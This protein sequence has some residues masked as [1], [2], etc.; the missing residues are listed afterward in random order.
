MI[1][2]CA[3]LAVFMVL[4]TTAFASFAPTTSPIPKLRGSPVIL[5]NVA[6]KRSPIP[7]MRD[8]KSMAET[9]E[10]NQE[11]TTLLQIAELQRQEESFLQ[12]PK[13]VAQTE[14][15]SIGIKA[16]KVSAIPRLR[17]KSLGRIRD[18]QQVVASTSTPTKPERPK[19]AKRQRKKGSVC[20]V[21]SI[22]GKAV[23]RINGKGSCGIANPVKITAVGGVALTR[24]I[25]VNCATAKRLD[26]WVSKSAKPTI[27]RQGGG[28][29]AVQAIGG[30]S[31]R[32]RNSKRG[33]KLSEHAKGNA[34][35]IA[36]FKLKNGTIYSVKTDWRRGRAGNTLRKLHKSACGPF[37][38]VLGPN[39]DRHHHD[40]FHFDVA[41]H[42]GGAYCR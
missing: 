18:N 10:K 11:I 25:T 24:E 13:Q 41:N 42:R 7:R 33:A 36:G 37:G 20:G 16:I 28:L 8:S 35:D 9:K 21:R 22:R 23:S 6:I 29:V 5:S 17:P 1:K 3:G 19:K 39:S 34:V 40:H 4:A 2:A 26:N 15:I 30:Y 12:T 27:G 14:N 38:T 32:T 31:C